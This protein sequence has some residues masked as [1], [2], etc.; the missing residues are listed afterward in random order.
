MILK[1][2]FNYFFKILYGSG[3]Y[4]KRNNK[5]LFFLMI[6]ADDFQITAGGD[7]SV[8]AVKIP[9]PAAAG[10]SGFRRFI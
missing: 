1:T 6:D 9:C 3:I 5:E 7:Y 2:T 4:R 10:R 8:P